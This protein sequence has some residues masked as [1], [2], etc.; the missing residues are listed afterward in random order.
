MV[1]KK[2]AQQIHNTP[3]P[4]RITLSIGSVY[5]TIKAD[6]LWKSTGKY[7]ANFRKH[8]C[9]LLKSTVL[10][11]MASQRCLGLRRDWDEAVQKKIHGSTTL[12]YT[13]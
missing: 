6:L 11:L 9:L 10:A 12:E 8:D 7:S 1:I 13:V 5:G 3:P 2:P 4:T